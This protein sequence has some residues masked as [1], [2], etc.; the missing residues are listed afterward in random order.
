MEMKRSMHENG[1]ERTTIRCFCY[2]IIVLMLSAT[3]AAGVASYNYLDGEEGRDFQKEV[4]N[5]LLYWK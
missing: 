2:F 1:F 5:K 3:I 4:R